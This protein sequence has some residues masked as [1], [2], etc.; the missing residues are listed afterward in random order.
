[1]I[2]KELERATRYK[3]PVSL[4]MIDIDHFKNINDTYGHQTGDQVLKE[5]AVIFNN[6]IRTSDIAG[7][8]GGEEFLLV[9]PELDHDKALALAERIRTGVESHLIQ[10]EGD[11]IKV[12]ISLGISTYPQHGDSPNTLI[13][14][15]D[16]AMYAAKENGRNQVKSAG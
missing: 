6:T 4:I 5:L 16:D 8:F 14:A 1:M 7:R 2:T 12:T 13:K 15:C 3:R 11:S 9:L 10:F